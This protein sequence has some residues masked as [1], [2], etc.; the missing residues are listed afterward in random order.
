MP[1]VG[2]G[3]SSSCPSSWKGG[4]PCP[5][6]AGLMWNLQ[7]SHQSQ[8][9]ADAVLLLVSVIQPMRLWKGLAGQSSASLSVLLVLNNMA[10]AR[11]QAA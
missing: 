11:M 4:A 10:M 6:L 3:P 1:S 5:A 2:G 9:L 7:D 8:P